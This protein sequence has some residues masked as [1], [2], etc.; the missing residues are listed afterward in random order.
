[1]LLR[2][3][4]PE[5]GTRTATGSVSTSKPSDADDALDAAVASAE[6]FRSTSVHMRKADCG[7]SAEALTCYI[8]ATHDGLPERRLCLEAARRFSGGPSR[9]FG[10][11]RG[12]VQ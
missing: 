4:V 7:Q 8:D 11:S 12:S 6:P 2:A 3:G 9:H 5:L 10:I 1:V